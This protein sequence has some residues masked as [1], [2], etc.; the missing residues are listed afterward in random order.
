MRTESHTMIGTIRHHVIAWRTREGWSRET[1]VQAI[2][3]A[4]ERIGAAQ[5]TG[6]VFDPTTRDT[7]ERMKVNADRVFRWLDDQGK[8]NNL[9]PANFIQSIWA[10]MPIDVRLHCIGDCVR[11]VGASVHGIKEAVNGDFDPLSHLQC[12]IKETSEAQQALL[13]AKPGSGVA[14]LVAARKEIG[15]VI[16][17]AGKTGRELDTAIARQSV[18]QV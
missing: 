15:D 5:L 7:F 9:L 16:E 8:D 3:E 17:L 18:T 1:V 11:P 10:A 12:L 13:G 2:V 6:I 4:H 14:A